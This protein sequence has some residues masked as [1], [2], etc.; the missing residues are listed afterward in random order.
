MGIYHDLSEF[1]RFNNDNIWELVPDTEFPNNKITCYKREF[2]KRLSSYED[3]INQTINEDLMGTEGVNNNWNYNDWKAF[4][5][6]NKLKAIANKHEAERTSLPLIYYM[7]YIL[8]F[9]D[10]GK[11]EYVSPTRY[12]FRK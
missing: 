2:G 3:R 8:G 5:G 4:F 11:M 9:N 7:K 12:I 1:I 6:E 10:D